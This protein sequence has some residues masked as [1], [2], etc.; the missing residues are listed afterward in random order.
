MVTASFEGLPADPG[1]GPIASMRAG[2]EDAF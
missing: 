1:P 2:V